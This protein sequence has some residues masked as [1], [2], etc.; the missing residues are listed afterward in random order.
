MQTMKSYTNQKKN[1][2]K[3][4]FLRDKLQKQERKMGLFDYIKY[5]SKGEKMF[6]LKKQ[7]IWKQQ[8]NTVKGNA[9]YIKNNITTSLHKYKEALQKNCSTKDE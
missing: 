5:F 6:T 3:E 9:T 7:E 2:Y 4:S 1:W 8:V